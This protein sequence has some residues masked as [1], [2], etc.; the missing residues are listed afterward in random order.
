MRSPASWLAARGMNP[1]AVK[2]RALAGMVI[3]LTVVAIDRVMGF[4][5]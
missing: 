2:R 1:D 4:G 5:S 3:G